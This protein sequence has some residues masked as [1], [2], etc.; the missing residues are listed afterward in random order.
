MK[1]ILSYPR[2]GNHLVRFFIELL[3]EKPTFGI[4]INKDD[5]EIYK[6]KFS[7]DIPFNIKK[8]DKNECY[9]KYHNIV[10]S[11]LKSD[12][13]IFIL[14]DPLEVLSHKDNNNWDS[15]IYFQNI[16]FYNKFNK[17]KIL[18]FYE[19][20]INNKHKFINDLY[21][22]LNIKNKNKL[23]YILENIDSLYNLSL[24]GKN[25]DWSGN[26]SNTL[27]RYHFNFL[28]INVKKIIEK[29]I[30]SKSKKYK[31]LNRYVLTK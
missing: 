20:I 5:T 16:K 24:N 4:D 7:K 23:N 15:K 17:K 10:N 28:P 19:D 27:I 21:I 12:E 1:A 22:F 2:S 25:R 6:N 11:L 26:N 8:Y 14:R 3:S 31:V 18:F 30:E 9:I 29:Y 13:L